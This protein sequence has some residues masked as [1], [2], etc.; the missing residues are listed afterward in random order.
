[1]N[2]TIE[3][4]ADI[5]NVMRRRASAADQ[6]LATFVRQA[7]TES[8]IATSSAKSSNFLLQR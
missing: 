2:L 3:L 7:V 8:A 4:P 6:D 1:M 5:E